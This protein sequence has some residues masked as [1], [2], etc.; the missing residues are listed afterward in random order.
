MQQGQQNESAQRLMEFVFGV[1]VSAITFTPMVII[2]IAANIFVFDLFGLK[3]FG[4]FIL[5]QAEAIK[6]ALFL[7]TVIG[8]IGLFTTH[9]GWWVTHK[10][11]GNAITSKTANSY[12]LRLYALMTVALTLVFAVIQLPFAMV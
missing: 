10:R 8:L 3:F 9:L 5:D 2:S 4:S 11:A 7:M 6:A 1:I 12:K